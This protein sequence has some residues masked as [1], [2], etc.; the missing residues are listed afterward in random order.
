MMHISVLLEESIESLNL[1]DDSVVIDMTLGYGG[2]SS[3]IL[4][5]IKR[6]YL[7]AF[8]QDS[9]AIEASKLK[10]SKI[11]SNYEIINNN[12]VN[13]KQE[14]KKRHIK[15]VDAILF[16][17]GVSSPQLDTSERGFSYHSDS[18]LD[19]RMDRSNELSAYEVINNYS[20]EQLKKI[21]FK[22]G[23]EKYASSIAKGIIREREKKN[24]DS[25]NELVE[26]IKAN[27]P[28]KYKRNKHPARKVFQALRIE[29]NK[30]LEVLEKT[31]IDSLDLLAVGGRIGVI[32]FHSLEDRICKNIFNQYSKLDQNLLKLPITPKEYEPK[33]KIIGLI[34]PGSE[35]IQKNNRARSAKLRIIERIK[36]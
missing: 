4:E 21:F 24:I 1:K 23:E 7:F 18:K 10:L 15:E 6:G 16:D 32:T 33:Y 34:L 5:K 11:A 13:V 12:F 22:Y 19:M 30:E 17:L 36:E 31:L 28:D 26:I 29:V 14:M 3:L 27:V 9:D 20:Y 25:T 8:D 35:E 2:H